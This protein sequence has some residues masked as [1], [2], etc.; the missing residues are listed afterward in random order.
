MAGE[1]SFPSP[2]EGVPALRREPLAPRPAAVTPRASLFPG[3]EPLSLHHQV[4][5]LLRRHP[6]SAV[7]LVGPHG[8]GKTAALH[9]LV[10]TLPPDSPVVLLDDDGHYWAGGGQLGQDRLVIRAARGPDREPQPALL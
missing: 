8:S 1:G 4:Q 2:N 9:H 3:G 7:S 10:A 5:G 6:G